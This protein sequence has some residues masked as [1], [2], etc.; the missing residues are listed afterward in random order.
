MITKTEQKQN[1]TTESQSSQRYY[2]RQDL[3]DVP[4]SKA[5]KYDL[6]LKIPASQG[7]N[8]N[9]LGGADNTH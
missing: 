8:S 5:F 2:F 4:D 6:Y 9:E 3:L 7:L 1:F